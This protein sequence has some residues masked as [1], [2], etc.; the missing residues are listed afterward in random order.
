MILLITD[1]VEKSLCGNP[2]HRNKYAL[3][4]KGVIVSKQKMHY[5]NESSMDMNRKEKVKL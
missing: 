5:I 1:N 2:R 3:Q 4:T